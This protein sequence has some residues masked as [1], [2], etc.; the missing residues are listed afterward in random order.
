MEKGKKE[1][2]KENEQTNI[3]SSRAV[4][5]ANIKIAPKTRVSYTN[6]LGVSADRTINRVP[7]FN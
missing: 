7:M 1:N 3:I 5:L 4:D 6:G 2:G